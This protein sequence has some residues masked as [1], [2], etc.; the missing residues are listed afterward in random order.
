M[1]RV[2]GGWR[3]HSQNEVV[4]GTLLLRPETAQPERH[5]RIAPLEAP[6]ETRDRLHET[7]ASLDMRELVQQDDHSPAW[8]PRDRFWRQKQRRSKETGDD[9]NPD[10]RADQQGHRPR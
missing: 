8:I 4:A 9:R 6:R 10:S 5:Q 3:A 7:V 2:V 1:A